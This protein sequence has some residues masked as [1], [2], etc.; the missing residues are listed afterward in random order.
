MAITFFFFFA[1]KAFAVIR[2]G[3]IDSMNP[4]RGTW[5]YILPN[6]LNQLGG[7]VS[8]V[9]NLNSLMIYLKNQGLQYVIIKAADEDTVFTQGGSPQLTPAFVQAGHAVG[10]KVYGY[11]YTVGKNIPGEIAMCNNIF[12]QGADGLIYDAEVEWEPT[13]NSTTG[14]PN[15]PWLT[16]APAQATQLCSTVRS[17]WPTKYIGL[18]TWP[19]RGFH[20]SLPYK[21]FARYCDVIMP[22]AY[23]IEIGDTPTV[24]VAHINTDWLSWKNGLTGVWTNSI[25]P[26]VMTGQGWSSTNGTVTPAQIAEF[27]NCLRTNT[28]LLSPGGFK[29][30]DYWRAELHSSSTWNAIRTNSISKP[31]TNAPVIEYLPVVIAAATTANISWPTD[32]KSDGVVEYGLT[33]SYGAL[34]TNATTQWY[35]TVGLTGLDPDTTY[36]YRVKSTGTNNL[37]GVS[38][39]Y[40]FTTTPAAVAD[41]IIDNPAATVAGSWNT[42]T[43]SPDKF[44]ADYRYKSQGTGA[45]Y[46]RFI[47]NFSLAGNY[48]VYEW[49]PIGV[50]RTTGAK[51]VI[52]YNG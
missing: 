38:A 42:G 50:N 28:S 46:L 19:Y 47:P 20:S 33:T 5:I 9:T 30:I 43:S 34:K 37:T 31:Y 7:N 4:G 51:H 18:S 35:R 29:G 23:W 45:N 15:H 26:F 17:N 48:Q 1:P 2:D 21:E 40:L 49:H 11:I 52:T 13:T 41:I 27:E 22:Q 10:L 25:K 36:H 3:G 6:A 44:G 32:Q 39:D 24:C 16:N 8:S 12:N 14:L